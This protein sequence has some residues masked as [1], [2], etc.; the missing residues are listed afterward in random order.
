M[1]LG[2][3][4]N[5]LQDLEHCSRK[6]GAMLYQS[7]KILI[8]FLLR[9]LLFVDSSG[10]GVGVVGFAFAGEGGD[11]LHFVLNPVLALPHVGAG[12]LAAET[13]VPAAF[14]RVLLRRIHNNPFVNQF[15]TGA[16]AMEQVPAMA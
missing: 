2:S 1:L 3:G 11:E 6:Q 13:A 9:L 5:A 14:G 10:D 7:C 12:L 15:P 16:L 8:V 4:S